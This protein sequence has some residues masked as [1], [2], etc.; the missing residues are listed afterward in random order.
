MI[1]L[2]CAAAESRQYLKVWNKDPYLLIVI[3]MHFQYLDLSIVNSWA[4]VENWIEYEIKFRL[5]S[6]NTQWENVI[7]EGKRK[8][9]AIVCAIIKREESVSASL[10][11][12]IPSLR[13][14][15]KSVHFTC[16][17]TGQNTCCIFAIIY[18]H[19]SVRYSLD[20]SIVVYEQRHF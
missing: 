14:L 2:T 19:V 1:C 10:S 12:S 17:L 4:Y 8:G 13:V 20:K 3:S 6:S 15:F 16:S 9:A 18:F 7:A 5:R 11:V